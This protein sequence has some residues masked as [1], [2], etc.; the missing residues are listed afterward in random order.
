MARG[1]PSYHG[2]GTQIKVGLYL[3]FV[4]PASDVEKEPFL[5]DSV[6]LVS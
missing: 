1:F 3:F 4:I 6:S 5:P 2:S